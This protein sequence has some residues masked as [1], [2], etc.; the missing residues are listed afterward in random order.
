MIIKTSE[1]FCTQCFMF[2]Y[3]LVQ[4]FLESCSI[5]NVLKRAFRQEQKTRRDDE[6]EN[7]GSGKSIIVHEISGYGQFFH[8]KSGSN[9][10]KASSAN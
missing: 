8:G 1:Y 9:T 4:Y 7:T 3:V 6:E 5:T 10:K 2:C